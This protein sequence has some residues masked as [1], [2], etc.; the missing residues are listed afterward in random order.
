MKGKQNW[1]SKMPTK[2]SLDKLLH[3]RAKEKNEIH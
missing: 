1:Q 2:Y 3:D